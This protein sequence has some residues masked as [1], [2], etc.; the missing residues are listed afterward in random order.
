MT[1]AGW[2]SIPFPRHFLWHSH[3]MHSTSGSAAA[4]PPFL[5]FFLDASVPG[6]AYFHSFSPSPHMW[7]I[8]TLSFFIHSLLAYYPH[9]HRGLQPGALSFRSLAFTPTHIFQLCHRRFDDRDRLGTALSMA[10]GSNRYRTWLP[11]PT[12]LFCPGWKS[13]WK[14]PGGDTFPKKCVDGCFRR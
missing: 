10:Q 12:R 9:L 11:W 3:C 5:G 1:L 14:R 4:Y 8:P 2:F 6:L 7:A 13:W